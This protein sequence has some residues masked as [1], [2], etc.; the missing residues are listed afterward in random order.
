VNDQVRRIEPDDEEISEEWLR[1]TDES[2]IR[3]V[4]AHYADRGGWIV[5][6]WAQEFY[7]QDPLGVELRQRIQAALRAVEGVTDV[8][9]HDNESWG[10]TGTPSGE[11]LTRAAARVVDEL[12]EPVVGSTGERDLERMIGTLRRELLDRLLIVNEH[13]LRHVLTEYLQ[14]YNT[15]RPH[16]ALGQLTPLQAG[17][18]PPEPVNLTDH[19]IRWKQVLGGLTNEYYAAA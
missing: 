10:I 12:A 7:R 15:A 8:H 13:H 17:T 11:A 19:R 4:G 16:R 6:V 3:G 18:R 14:H 1:E 9:E 2:E 5:S